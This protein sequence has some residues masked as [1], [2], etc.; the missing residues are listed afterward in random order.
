[1]RRVA[2]GAMVAALFAAPAFAAVSDMDTDGDGLASYE[3]MMAVY[4]DLTEDVFAEIDT[5]DDDLVDEDEL[6][7]ALE[8]GTIMEPAQ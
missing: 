5:S 4:T 2:V 3:E 8:A 6:A 7:A 1:M